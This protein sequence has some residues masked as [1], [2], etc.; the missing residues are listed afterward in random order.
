MNGIYKFILDKNALLV[1]CQGVLKFNALSEFIAKNSLN[2]DSFH[3]SDMIWN[4]SAMTEFKLSDLERMNLLKIMKILSINHSGKMLL[5]VPECKDPVR[6]EHLSNFTKLINDA[7]FEYTVVEALSQA[8]DWL[9]NYY[10]FS[11][12]ANVVNK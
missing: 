4:L 5:V 2:K 7:G 3:D 10:L 8:L 6:T 12:D 1:E 9:G 11:K